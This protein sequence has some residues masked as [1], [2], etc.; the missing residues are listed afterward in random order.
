MNKVINININGLIFHIDEEAFVVLDRYLESL[1]QHFRNNE[2]GSEILADIEARIAEMLSEMLKDRTEVVSMANVQQ[3][4]STM[5][6]PE[7]MDDADAGA[8]SKSK[9][10]SWRG[11][12]SFNPGKRMYRDTDNKIIGGVCSGISE[13][14]DIDPVWIRLLF[15]AVFF[16]FGTG[17]L[18]YIILWIILP[19]ATTPSEK[20]EMR[21]ERINISNIEKTVTE[22]LDAL[23]QR[24]DKEFSKFDSKDF[25]SKVNNFFHGLFEGLEGGL[26]GIFHV[27]AWLFSLIFILI[28]ACVLIAILSVIFGV[29]GIIGFTVPVIFFDVFR[30][31]H[32]ATWVFILILLVI[33]LP[34]LGLM[35]RSLRYISGYRGRGRF[36]NAWFSTIW[37]FALIALI[38]LAFGSASGFRSSYSYTKIDILSKPAHDTLYLNAGG[39]ASD[40][41]NYHGE[42]WMDLNK[43]WRSIEQKNDTN[44]IGMVSLDINRSEDHTVRLVKHFKSRGGSVKDAMGNAESIRYNYDQHDSLLSFDEAFRI[45]KGEKWHGQ[46]VTLDLQIP[47]GT[48][49]KMRKNMDDIIYD[50]DNVQDMDDEEMPSH[51]WIMKPDG[52]TCLD[53]GSDQHDWNKNTVRH[54]EHRS[55]WEWHWDN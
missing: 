48:V 4:I 18:I 29:T 24:I 52:L 17:L 33:G 26:R 23:K 36:L 5:G 13:Y 22:N 35:F 8:G 44:R 28:S 15:V 53:C 10:Y 25:G 27:F 11:D 30:D 43:I 50:I 45:P 46:N 20:L 42:G 41:E 6:K 31:S 12:Y 40:I 49:I 39:T 47:D 9:S 34:F 21:G 1:K 51:L 14:L 54:R 2:G 37:V 3:V 55:R 16:G 38:A 19:A 32:Q 7:D